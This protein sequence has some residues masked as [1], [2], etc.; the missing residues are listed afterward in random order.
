KDIIETFNL[1]K[2]EGELIYNAKRGECIF[3][4]GIRKI[5]AILEID[6]EE[7]RVIDPKYKSEY[8]DD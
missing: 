7:L 1:T 2:T 4:A 8:G 5:Y 3:F 6:L